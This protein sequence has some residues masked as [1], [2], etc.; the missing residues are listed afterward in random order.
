MYKIWIQLQLC[1]VHSR[2]LRHSPCS[3]T[4][5][6]FEI[7]TGSLF[8]WQYIISVSACTAVCTVTLDYLLF[9]F[10][11]NTPFFVTVTVTLKVIITFLRYRQWSNAI[12]FGSIKAPIKRKKRMWE[13]ICKNMSCTTTAIQKISFFLFPASCSVCN[14]NIP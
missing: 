7:L 2:F 10:T 13:W 12:L 1:F 11:C 4:P 6:D 3:F 14:E 5:L 8:S 9:C